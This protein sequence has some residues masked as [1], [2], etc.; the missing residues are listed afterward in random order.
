MAGGTA[1]RRSDSDV[2]GLRRGVDRDP[3]QN[4]ASQRRAR[5]AVRLPGLCSAHHG[6]GERAGVNDGGGFRGIE[7]FW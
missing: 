2:L 1:W 6:G 4:L 7:R 3:R 5:G